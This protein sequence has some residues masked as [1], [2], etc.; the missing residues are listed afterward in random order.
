LQV[1]ATTYDLDL[2]GLANGFYLLNIQLEHGQWGVRK[3]VKM[4]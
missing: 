2:K 3:L 4:D 1:N